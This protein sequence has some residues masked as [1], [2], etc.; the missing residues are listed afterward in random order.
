VAHED[1]LHHAQLLDA[2]GQLVE[3]GRVE[4]LARLELAGFAEV[5]GEE[6]RAVD[7][8]AVEGQAFGSVH[9]ISVVGSTA[10]RSR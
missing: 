4:A 8:G 1:G 6:L 3:L 7:R 10:M 2:V 5:D 9:E